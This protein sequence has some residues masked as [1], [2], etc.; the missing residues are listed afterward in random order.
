MPVAL[1]CG[2]KVARRTGQ[3]CQMHV[4]GTGVQKRS[5]LSLSSLIGCVAAIALVASGCGRTTADTPTSPSP[6]PSPSPAASP[7]PQFPS[8]PIGQWFGG[9]S[10]SVTDRATGQDVAPFGVSCGIHY[11][12]I[13]SQTGAEFSGF[14]DIQG[15]GN[16]SD[17][18][19]NNQSRM[20]GVM[21]ADG[22]VSSLRFDPIL[23]SGH[24]V[25]VSG[26]EHF[27]GV[28]VVSDDGTRIRTQRSDRVS[29]RHPYTGATI[30]G[31]RTTIV[32]LTTTRTP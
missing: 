6:T 15:N 17:P 13:S 30:E 12:S 25:H 4:L 18:L 7:P 22:T 32:N 21:T 28:V 3:S 23:R 9:F 19:C 2:R 10:A 11:G 20:T 29:C 14:V 5:S 16:N 1:Q 24:C 27:T 26:D 31:D 8:L